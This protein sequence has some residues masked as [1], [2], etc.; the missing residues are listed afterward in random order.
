MIYKFILSISGDK[1]DL[2]AIFNIIEGNFIV[3]S[4]FFASDKKFENRIDEYGYSSISF[5]HPLKYCID[6]NID[7]YEHS[8]IEFINQ[9][10]SSFLMCGA[11]DFD[12]YMEI[13]FDGQQCNFEIFNK[14]QLKKLAEYG[15]SL[16]ISIYMLE[17]EYYSKWETEIR[18]LWSFK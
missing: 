4:Y 1:F 3:E 17:D 7:K 9:N 12:I 8:F 15:F 14:E 18:N 11:T 13:Y 16:P 2:N 5:F 6:D 10:I